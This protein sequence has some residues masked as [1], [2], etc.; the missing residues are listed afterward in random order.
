M[1]FAI[2]ALGS[3]VGDRSKNLEFARK[4]VSESFVIRGHSNVYQS[5]PVDFLNQP[6][7]F[8]QV[9]EIEIPSN[10]TAEVLFQLIKKI[11]NEAGPAKVVFKGPRVL[12][13]D[14]IFFKLETIDQVHLR[15]PHPSWS[16]RDF[17][18]FPLQ[19]LPSFEKIS[20]SH[21]FI[22]NQALINNLIKV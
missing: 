14:I 19:E 5:H 11:E 7:F 3:N 17:V 2:L 1:A 8:N 12:D 21:L 10:L 6:D 22:N 16:Q 9:I 13:I 4:K 20:K 15:I 18:Y